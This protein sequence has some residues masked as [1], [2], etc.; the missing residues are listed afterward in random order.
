MRTLLVTLSL[1]LT[2]QA[3]AAPTMRYDEKTNLIMPIIRS[4]S[5]EQRV[6]RIEKMLETLMR[7]RQK[8]I[9]YNAC[10]EACS[11]IPYVKGEDYDKS[12]RNTCHETCKMPEAYA[13]D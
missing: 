2:V 5:P 13:G 11:K 8:N 6:I 3:H 7:D 9:A 1:C 10:H 12:K 4:D